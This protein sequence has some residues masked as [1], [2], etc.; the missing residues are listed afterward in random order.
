MISNA[1]R[2]YGA[3]RAGLDPRLQEADVFRRVS[4]ALRLSRDDDGPRRARALADNRRLWLAV[5]G[6]VQDPTNALPVDLRAQIASVS[7]A[8]L[9][10]LNEPQPDLDFLIDINDMLAI[11]LSSRR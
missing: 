7:H 1:A 11:G 4:G 3:S 9:R 10:E 2:A 5:G 8:V 6:V